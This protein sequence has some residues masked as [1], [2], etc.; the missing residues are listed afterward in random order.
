M[1]GIENS[2]TLRDL[3][4]EASSTTAHESDS[5]DSKSKRKNKSESF[6]L[7]K[8]DLAQLDVLKR[9]CDSTGVKIGKTKLLVAGLHI[10]SAMPLGKLLAVIGPLE[11]T[12]QRLQLKRKKHTVGS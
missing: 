7:S 12:N 10:L 2:E 5:P 6:S 1:K 8:K 4:N 3:L 11:P 9:R